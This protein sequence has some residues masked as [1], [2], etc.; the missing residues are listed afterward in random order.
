MTHLPGSTGFGIDDASEIIV[1]FPDEL[2]ADLL[3]GLD[4]FLASGKRV[5]FQSPGSTCIKTTI[6]L[7]KRG[8]RVF[9]GKSHPQPHILFDR[10]HAFELPPWEEV[11]DAYDLACKLVWSRIAS[12]SLVQGT[13]LSIGS[14]PEGRL[15]LLQL[16][17]MPGLRF[18]L[19]TSADM[20]SIGRHVEFLVR[21]DFGAGRSIPIQKGIAVL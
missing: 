18:A 8:Y 9:E 15:S 5:E 17:E 11:P 16:A 3:R 4:G 21:N 1:C 19:A 7:L 6:A 20:P 12:F 13:L 10:R 14:L 2:S